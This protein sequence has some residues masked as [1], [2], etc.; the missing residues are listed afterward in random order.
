MISI[1]WQVATASIRGTSH[2]RH[3]L[4]NQD[5]VACVGAGTEDSP[6]VLAVADGH[7]SAKS[8]RSDRGS[9]FAVETATAVMAAS[10]KNAAISDI[11]WLAE[12]RISK[13]LVREWRAAVERDAAAAAFTHEESALSPNP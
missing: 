1:A 10:L 2:I 4:P 5:A 7:G 9:R 6:L 8:F 3:G 11:Q 12:E 13:I